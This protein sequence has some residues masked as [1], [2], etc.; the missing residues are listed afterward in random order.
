M[1]FP[2]GGRATLSRRG[3]ISLVEEIRKRF[4]TKSKRIKIGIGDDAAVVSLPEGGQCPLA[5]TT[6]MMVEGVHFD[7]SYTTAYQ[8]GFK[9]ISVNVSD[10]YAM[11]GR[12]LYALLDMALRGDMEESFLREFLDGVGAA[13]RL[14]KVSL[15]GGDLSSTPDR[16]SLSATLLGS[17]R[18]PVTRAGARPGDSVYVTGALGDSAGGLLLLKRLKRR[19][20]FNRPL[21]KPLPWETMEPLLRRHL[22]PVAKDPLGFKTARAMIDI[23]DGLLID[24]TRLCKESVAGVTIYEEMIP[25]SEELKAAASY[26]KVDALS[27]AL[28]GGED[29]ELL[30][31]SPAKDLHA[32]KPVI[33]IGE[34]T[35]SGR[36]IVQ[37]NG[38][39]KRMEPGGYAHFKAKT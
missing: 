15:I 22:M 32:I 1:R 20:D 31:T 21:D 35:R 28:S 39:K 11:A 23:S 2:A 36:Y 38:R 14:Y 10:I 19:I 5:A 24:L 37:R 9:L 6:D 29:Y 30:F 8:L 33:K 27:L 17:V 25:V 26:L 12:P 13:C 16:I 7:L 3:E 4:S 18:K 34:I